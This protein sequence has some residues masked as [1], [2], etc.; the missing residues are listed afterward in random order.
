MLPERTAGTGRA[1]TDGAVAH[2]ANSWQRAAGRSGG[3]RSQS[4]RWRDLRFTS[5]PRY[6]FCALRVVSAAAYVRRAPLQPAEATLPPHTDGLA[7]ICIVHLPR[8]L[9]SR[10]IERAL[11]S[12]HPGRSFRRYHFVFPASHVPWVDIELSAGP[13]DNRPSEQLSALISGLNLP[14]LLNLLQFPQIFH[15]TVRFHCVLPKLW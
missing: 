9:K 2:C 8:R 4:G 14:K 7:A 12:Y 1:S 11:E 13:S 5:P 15:R 10:S 6:L 3:G